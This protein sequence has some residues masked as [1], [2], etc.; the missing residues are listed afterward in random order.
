VASLPGGPCIDRSTDATCDGVQ[1][2]IDSVCVP[3]TPSLTHEFSAEIVAQQ[4]P[5]SVGRTRN[6]CRA[7]EVD[8]SFAYVA[9]SFENVSATEANVT[10]RTTGAAD[11]TLAVYSPTYIDDDIATGCFVSNDDIANNNQRSQ[12]TFRLRSGSSGEFVVS[13]FD[14]NAS[15][16]FGLTVTSDVPIAVLPLIR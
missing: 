15:F 16:P 11:T 6:G 10:A 9:F 8:Q 4:E 14:A 13:G 7:Q 12:V 2:C 3:P 1:S 5:T